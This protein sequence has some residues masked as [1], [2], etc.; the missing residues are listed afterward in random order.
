MNSFLIR[1]SSSDLIIIFD[2]LVNKTIE[3]LRDNST[4]TSYFSIDQD[5]LFFIDVVAKTQICGYPGY[6]AQHPDI[7]V[8]ELVN[9]HIDFLKKN[10]YSIKNVDSLILHVMHFSLVYNDI[11]TK[12]TDMYNA[13]T[14]QNCL[15]NAKLISTTLSMANVDPNS[16]GLSIFNAS[17]Y[18]TKLAGEVAYILKCQAHEVKI[19][20]A[21]SCFNEI[22]IV[23][24]GKKAFLSPRSRLITDVG[25]SISCD[26]FFP[27]IYQLNGRW[28]QLHE[29][30]FLIV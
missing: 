4:K 8:S 18:F 2:G 25:T 30:K 24:N 27:P 26:D 9:F 3:T 12:M 7:L 29:G 5:R 23:Y 14:Q 20:T 17:G 6:L 28:Y 11:A 19:R 10:D 15:T 1:C 16:L 22:P 21:K 13:F